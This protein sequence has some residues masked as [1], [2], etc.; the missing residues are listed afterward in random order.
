MIDTSRLPAGHETVRQA[1]V[2]ADRRRRLARALGAAVTGFTAGL[3]P[4]VALGVL[5]LAI[6]LPAWVWWTAIAVTGGVTV[7]LAAREWLAAPALDRAGAALD[8]A[9]GLPD[10]L[11]SVE[12][13]LRSDEAQSPWVAE[14]VARAA[15]H[16]QGLDVA[17]L[18]P[19][20]PGRARFTRAAVLMGALAILLAIPPTW[21]RQTLARFFDGNAGEG[22]LA[23]LTPE[24]AAAEAELAEVPAEELLLPGGAPKPVNGSRMLEAFGEESENGESMEGD[25]GDA[26]AAGEAPDGAQGETS[27]EQTRPASRRDA[28]GRGEQPSK[29]E[30]AAKSDALQE[31]LDR[32]AEAAESNQPTDE[33]QA[34][35]GEQQ[36]QASEQAGNTEGNQG[37]KKS[38]EKREGQDGQSSDAGAKDPNSS[39]GSQSAAGAADDPNG[40]ILGERTALDVTLKRE[41]LAS[42]LEQGDDQAEAEEREK[43]T[44]RGA[45]SRGYQRVGPVGSRLPAGTQPT[46]AVPWAY[47]DLV[48]AY[49]LDRAAQPAQPKPEQKER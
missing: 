19:V 39:G 24:E 10:E 46:Q 3:A 38:G 14:L 26:E 33:K 17:R 43:A 7:A 36:S 2:Q 1:L 9:A 40:N 6:D 20:A 27:G 29:P 47:Q 45:A 35:E 16:S 44:E 31:A 22:A 37:G 11:G 49:F 41:Q 5:R 30:D 23:S 28:A 18:L 4:L 25:A 48:R 8:K 32:A 12:W 15:E 13:F 21:S 42:A 34:G